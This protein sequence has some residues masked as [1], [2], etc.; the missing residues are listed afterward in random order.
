VAAALQLVLFSASFS[1]LAGSAAAAT[2]SAG[3]GA[4]LGSEVERAG[5][6]F[7]P[8][9]F[10]RSIRTQNEGDDGA[11]RPAQDAPV[12]WVESE[13]EPDAEDEPGDLPLISTFAG[14]IDLGVATPH[15]AVPAY[16]TLDS[17]DGRRSR[18]PPIG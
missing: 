1:A 15:G 12:C 8:A 2:L 13:S 18:G 11:A 4:G 14:I 17:R 3:E 10:S 9:S 6:A 5:S 16:R 7:S